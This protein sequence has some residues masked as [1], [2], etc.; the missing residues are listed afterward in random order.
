MRAVVVLLLLALS[1]CG[2]MYASGEEPSAW[3]QFTASPDLDGAVVGASPG[4][5]TIAM[6]FASWCGHC[7]R[8]VGELEELLSRR[9]D[10]RVIGVSFRHHEEY[11][12]RGDSAAVR[13]FVRD[14]APWMRVIPG[15]R[16]LWR[17]LG[18]PTFVPAVYVFDRAGALV[19]SYDRKD[20][21]PPDADELDALLTR[22][23]D[24]Q[25]P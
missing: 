24:K 13:A 11:D 9:Q 10:V 16:A 23:R 12:Q 1:G 8:E 4:Q 21:D 15:D 20:R 5:A 17:S 19:A 2:A 22:L 18:A 25:A 3:Q 7:R 14:Q 6:V